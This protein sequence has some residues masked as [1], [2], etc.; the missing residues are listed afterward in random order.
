MIYENKC[1][2]LF[3][4]DLLPEYKKVNIEEINLKMFLHIPNINSYIKE[5]RLITYIDPNRRNVSYLSGMRNGRV[6]KY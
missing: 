1:L 4:D 6:E 3:N 2:F 5:S